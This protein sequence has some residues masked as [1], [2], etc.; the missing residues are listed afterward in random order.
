MEDKRNVTNL[1]GLRRPFGYLTVSE[2]QGLWKDRYEDQWHVERKV[3]EGRTG[4][5]KTEGRQEG[6]PIYPAFEED[7]GHGI[8][9]D[10]PRKGRFSADG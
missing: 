10:A 6:V 7:N 4:A 2:L 1:N 8:D 3:V 9:W 5:T